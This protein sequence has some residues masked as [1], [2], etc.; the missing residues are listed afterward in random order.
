MTNPIVDLVKDVLARFQT[1]NA[2]FFPSQNNLYPIPFFGDIRKATV[3]TVALNP[4]W[5]EF[6]EGRHW[7][8]KFDAHTLTTRLLHYFD[9]PSPPPHRW[10][11]DRQDALALL[12]SSYGTNAAH[13]DLHPLP[14]KFRSDLT[15]EQRAKIG[16]AI[17][18]RS[19][20][21][22][23]KLLKLATQVRL[24]LV[25]DYTFTKSNG[26]PTK[27]YDFIST[28]G[29]IVALLGSFESRLKVFS[30]GGTGQ[31]ASRIGEERNSLRSHLKRRLS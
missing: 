20:I 7:L 26:T 24:L 11:R 30:A 19:P 14:T 23:A 17:E 18:T 3:L 15:E 16:S 27:T 28:H 25:V 9:L 12:D 10:F 31:F 2:D 5:T 22:L 29:P 21:H 6:R 13:I 1:A 4:A 8:P